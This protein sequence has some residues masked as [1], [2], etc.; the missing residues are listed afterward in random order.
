[1]LWPS[2]ATHNFV[3]TTCS[4]D[5]TSCSRE[6]VRVHAWPHQDHTGA[7]GWCCPLLAAS[8]PC[9]DGGHLLK[10]HVV[11]WMTFTTLIHLRIPSVRLE[12]KFHGVK[13]MGRIKNYFSCGN[14]FLHIF[15]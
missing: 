11:A 9:L 15:L 5:I 6:A 12:H 7:H 3:H 4:L 14:F 10:E 2:V 1:M 8:L 13:E